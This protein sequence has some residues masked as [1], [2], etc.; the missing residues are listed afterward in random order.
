MPSDELT[1]SAVSCGEHGQMITLYAQFDLTSASRSK[2]SVPAAPKSSLSEFL[3]ETR[4]T[5]PAE[6]SAPAPVEPLLLN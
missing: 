3:S 5:G 4:N 2:V 1:R 6:Q